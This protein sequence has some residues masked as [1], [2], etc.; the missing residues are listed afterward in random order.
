MN[1]LL[2]I[3]AP[4]GCYFPIDRCIMG[5]DKEEAGTFKN[6]TSLGAKNIAQVE[7]G[8]NGSQLII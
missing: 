6:G 1:D 3:S 5:C 2:G 8:N 7:W 4:G